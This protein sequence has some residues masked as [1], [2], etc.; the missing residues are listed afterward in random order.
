M[1]AD[2]EGKPRIAMILGSMEEHLEDGA[3]LCVLAPPMEVDRLTQLLEGRFSGLLTLFKV[4]IP[5]CFRLMW[6][7]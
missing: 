1:N 5:Y 3:D 2:S 7:S 6:Y 4:S